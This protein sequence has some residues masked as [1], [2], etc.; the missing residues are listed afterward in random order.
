MVIVSAQYQIVSVNH[1]ITTAIA[2]Q[3]TDLATLMAHDEFG[4][5]GIIGNQATGD[6]GTGRIGDDDGIAPLEPALDPNDAC[7]QQ[8]AAGLQ[9]THRASVDGDLAFRLEGASDPALA[10]RPR[11]RRGQEPAA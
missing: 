4:V 3:A 11:R 9:G 1:L 6:F 7:R 5:A 8:T 2:K 10:C